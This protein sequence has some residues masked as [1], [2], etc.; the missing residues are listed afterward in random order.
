MPRGPMGSL[1][2]RLS[3]ASL[4]FATLALAGGPGCSAK[5]SVQA[6]NDGGTAGTGGETTMDEYCEKCTPSPQAELKDCRAPRAV[7][8]CCVCVA[9]PPAADVKRGIGLH[10]FSSGDPT[11]NLGCL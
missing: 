10:Y 5:N 11:V 3:I 4:S 6:S 1:L 9:A 2:S 7:N 8:A